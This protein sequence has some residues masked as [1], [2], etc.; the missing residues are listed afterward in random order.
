MPDLKFPPSVEIKRVIAAAER[1]GIIVTSIE[2]H[3][4]KIIIFARDPNDKNPT[5]QTYSEWK[6]AQGVIR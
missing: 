3:P 2:I 6:A 1:A 4:R 5:R